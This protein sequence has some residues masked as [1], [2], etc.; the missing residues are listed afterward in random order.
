MILHFFCVFVSLTQKRWPDPQDVLRG[1][2]FCVLKVLKG[3][4]A[5]DATVQLLI[6]GSSQLLNQ[7]LGSSSFLSTL[8]MVLIVQISY[9]L[10]QLTEVPRELIFLILFLKSEDKWT[11]IQNKS[12]LILTHIQEKYFANT[13][14]SQSF[15]CLVQLFLTLSKNLAPM[16]EA[17]LE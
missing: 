6:I 9:A 3:N 1:F 11:I 13:Q 16:E 12:A 2:W 4:H 7:I 17:I 10:S 15:S 14:L 5:T 8:I